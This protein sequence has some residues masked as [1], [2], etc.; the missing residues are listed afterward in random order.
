MS[1]GLRVFVRSVFSFQLP[2]SSYQLGFGRMAGGV[3]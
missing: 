1:Y 3:W 2:V